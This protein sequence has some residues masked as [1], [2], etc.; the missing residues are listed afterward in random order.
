MMS[1][2]WKG[3]EVAV[4]V[5]NDNSLTENGLQFIEEAVSSMKYVLCV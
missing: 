2:W 1:G 5:A 3:R 4:R